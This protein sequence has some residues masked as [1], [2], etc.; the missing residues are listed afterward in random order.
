MADPATV[1]VDAACVADRYDVLSALGRGGMGKA[2][3]VR[4]RTSGAE[5]ALKRLTVPGRQGTVVELFEREF[6]TLNQLAHPRIVR[7]YDYGFD[8]DQDGEH[9]YYTMEL[10][11]GGD[12][13][14]VAPLPYREV[15]AIAYDICSALSL[16]HSRRLIHRDLTPRNVRRTSDG[17]AKLIDFGLLESFGPANTVAGTP[18]YVAPE[19]VNKISLDARSDLFSLGATLYFALTGRVAFRVTR[20]EQLRDAWRSTPSA[21]SKLVPEVPMA[22]DDLVMSLLRIDVGSRPKSAAEVMDRVAPLMAHPPDETLAVRGAYLTAPQ[23]VGSQ[24]MLTRARKQIAR[25]MRG[26]GG[27]FM[28]VGDPGTGRSRA[29]D[30]FVL[31][32]K[33]MGAATARAGASDGATGPLGVV[34]A[35]I[36]QIHQTARSTSVA[37]AQSDPHIQALLFGNAT[38]VETPLLEVGR[39]GL[40]RAHVQQTLRDFFLGVASKR[41]LSLAV[42]DFE[43]IDEPSAALLASLSIDANRF[44]LSYGVSA[45]RGSLD[46]PTTALAVLRERAHRVELKP[47]TALEVR[48]LLCGVFG[49]VPNLDGL[50]VQLHA[51]SLGRPRECLAL[52][53]HLVDA[54]VIT[55]R[56]GTFR[57]PA[58]VDPSLMPADTDGATRAQVDTIPEAALW[59]GRMLALCVTNRLTRSQLM[60]V[61]T[62]SNADTEA[63]I[64]SL[65]TLQAVA[66]SPKGYTMSHPVMANVMLASADGAQLRALHDQLADACR[67][68]QE[69]FAAVCHHGFRGNAPGTTLESLLARTATPEARATFTHEGSRQ[70]GPDAT[71]EAVARALEVA[72]AEQRPTRERMGMWSAIAGLSAAGADVRFYDAVATEWLAEL[73][74]A[75]GY[76]DWLELS[77]EVDPAARAVQAFVRA[78]QRFEA[79]PEGERV[80]PPVDAVKATVG[81]VIFSIAIAVRTLRTGLSSTL[82]ELLKPFATLNPLVDAMR[83]N[84]EASL[85]AQLGRYEDARARNVALIRTI[86]AL[87]GDQLAYM[88]KV[89]AAI[90][91]AIATAEAMLGIAN[92]DLDNWLPHEDESQR[93]GIEYVRKIAALHRG[94]WQAAEVHRRSAEMVALQSDA[95]PMFST[96]AEEL[97]AHALARDLTGLRNVRARINE[98]LATLPGWRPIAATAD[99][100]YHYL[101]GE[102]DV[103]L[104]IITRVR[105]RD[106]TAEARFRLRPLME[107]LA[108]EILLERGDATT[109]LAVGLR[110]LAHCEHAQQRHLA[111]L[112]ALPVALA[113]ARLGRHAQA[114]VRIGQVIEAQRALGVAGLLLGRSYEYMARC[115]IARGDAEAFRN[116]SAAAAVEYRPGRSEVLGALHERLVEDALRAGLIHGTH[117]TPTPTPTSPVS[118][119]STMVSASFMACENASARAHAAVTLLCEAGRTE[120]AYLY[121]LSEDGLMLSASAGDAPA[122]PAAMHAFALAQVELE[123]DNA[124]CTIT[125]DL[126][127][128]TNGGLPAEM[129]CGDRLFEPIPLL[130][131]HE[132]R[133]V[134]A[135]VALLA[136]PE[137]LEALT[138][139]AEA[140]ALHLIAFGDCRALDA[141]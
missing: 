6:H 101:C 83:L 108:V 137:A 44:R 49:D 109:A 3:R 94:D 88:Q 65:Q 82:P 121:L 85:C 8:P 132:G 36:T 106:D 68:T 26:R 97:E 141:G 90:C 126:S 22:V 33:L 70:I 5:L 55:Y 111:R 73:K 104:E 139:V 32:A 18:P 135:G 21:P 37:V 98:S 133:F 10:L 129:Q 13:R 7:A 64:R 114:G 56:A 77:D 17:A 123:Q 76:Q 116:A 40:D 131:T 117:A 100:Y 39:P 119:V 47:L 61:S 19:L 74:R 52:A 75:S 69:S 78:S 12:L 59:V 67:M 79:T 72:K 130:A 81:Y 84:A 103:A 29:L 53:Q 110:E 118:Q 124:V 58:A 46:N 42:D 80:M 128:P 57:L 112:V 24:E 43:L 28:V 96:L 122:D 51:R 138:P 115:A 93:V 136:E 50:A 25:S 4:D 16:L 38:G 60:A 30:T 89:R 31:E 66:G 11:D 14:E 95:A 99:A 34:Q 54:G 87:E 105:D 23:Q 62:M 125:A 134:L 27:G 86:D 45:Q 127:T 140:V 15:C 91:Q 9:A 92:E 63:G 113:E 48:E 120:G 1:D 102:P 41:L 107:A 35:L 20:F 2:Y 71:A